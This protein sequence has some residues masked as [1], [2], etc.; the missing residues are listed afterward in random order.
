MFKWDDKL[1]IGHDTVDSQHRNLVEILSAIEEGKKSGIQ[2]SQMLV[3]IKDLLDYSGYH[4][5]TEEQIMKAQ[6]YPHMNEHVREHDEFR[7][8]VTEFAQSFQSGSLLSTEVFTFLRSWLLKHI[9][10]TDRRLGTWLR[11]NT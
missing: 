11:T 3:H 2:K 8:Q 7:K 9:S 5:Q 10:G 6:A 4:L 1:A